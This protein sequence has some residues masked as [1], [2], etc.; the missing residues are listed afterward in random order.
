VQEPANLS[1]VCLQVY[2]SRTSVSINTLDVNDNNPDWMV[3]GRKQEC[4]S[5]QKQIVF[6]TEI[7]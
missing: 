6:G 7:I 5:S 1:P 2:N 3:F 4:D